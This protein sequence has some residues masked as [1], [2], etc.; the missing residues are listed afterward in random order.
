M[1]NTNKIYI[2]MENNGSNTVRIEKVDN[3]VI[4]HEN[5]NIMGKQTRC[6]RSFSKER[7]IDNVMEIYRQIGYKSN[8][9][10]FV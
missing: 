3:Q 9:M 8:G 4:A 7:D 10:E 1:T 5:I 6:T 2:V